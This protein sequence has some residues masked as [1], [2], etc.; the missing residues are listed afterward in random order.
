VAIT[1]LIQG[2]KCYSMVGGQR[3]DWQRWATAVTPPSIAHS[4]HNEGKVMALSLT[5]QDAGLHR[6]ARTMG[7]SFG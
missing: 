2:E 3:R 1:L 5:V 7:F 6:Y 4:V